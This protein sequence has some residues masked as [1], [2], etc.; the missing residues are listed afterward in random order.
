MLASWHR[1]A[2]E[3]RKHC[4][5]A[6][7]PKSNVILNEVKDLFFTGISQTRHRLA[8]VSER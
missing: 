8:L 1:M 2:W 5:L 3:P 4:L 6:W 7:H